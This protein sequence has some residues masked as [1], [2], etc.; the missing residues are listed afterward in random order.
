MIETTELIVPVI[1][2]F[3]A[4]KSTLINSL[5]G[6]K[7]L[8]TAV[9]P[10]T[11][12]A[13]EL[14][15]SIQEYIEAVNEDGS[16]QKFEISQLA[17]IKDNAQNFKYLRLY[18]NNQNLAEIQ[19]LIL[20]DMPGFNA[21][22]EKHNKAILEY[23][24]RGSYFIFVSSVEEAVLTSSIIKEI[25]NIRNFNKNFAFCL[26]KTDLKPENEV[27]AIKSTIESQ[28]QELFGFKKSLVLTNQLSGDNLKNILAEIEPSSL[29]KS[30]FIELLKDNY[31]KNS[32]TINTTIAT[33]KNSTQDSQF[34]IETLTETIKSIQ[35]KKQR[36]IADIESQYSSDSVND[37]I[38]DVGNELLRNQSRLIDLALDPNKEQEF[39]LEINEV[40]RN[41]LLSSVK[42]KVS[43]ISHNLIQDFGQELTRLNTIE[44]YEFDG[45]FTSKMMNST[46]LLLTRTSEGL[47][48]LNDRM[49]K[50]LE[51]KDKS[52]KAG[53]V[54]KAV[55]TIVGI[56]TSV[57]NP[58]V[59]V[60]IIFL[61]EII[62]FFT[63]G[64]RERHLQE[65]RMEQRQKMESLFLE[66]IIPDVKAKVRQHLQPVMKEQI[67]QLI[68]N[69]SSEFEVQISQKQQEI[70]QAI[71]EKELQAGE[72]DKKIANLQQAKQ[73]LSTVAKGVIFN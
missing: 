31:F 9:T 58:L 62:S 69:V 45:E 19:P 28:L 57:V 38:K 59:E 49:Q 66:R 64:M 17:E 26:N 1:G 5:L 20:V 22:I 53:S 54:Y 67:E 12:L 3:S 46:E 30:L 51:N 29:F 39:K 14:R 7:T 50:T 8:L 24:N 42:F 4:G 60:V 10:E 32:D 48:E 40:I 15:Y 36:S 35:M 55:A 71:A 37:I 44:N 72:I 6:T 33:L 65:Q 70:Q 23:L 27:M 47:K 61:P 52:Q 11:A 41:T 2:A 16:I 68:E 18:L 63:K 25:R 56:T 43:D 73:S 13:T 34:A 21:P